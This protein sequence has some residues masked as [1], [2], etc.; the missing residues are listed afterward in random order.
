MEGA[1]QIR[2]A[3]ETAADLA[4]C[5]RVTRTAFG[6]DEEADLVQ[7]LLNDPSA[8]PVLSLLAFEDGQ[9][10]GHILFTAARLVESENGGGTDPSAALL[11]PL[12]VVPGAQGRGVG[13]RLI[14]AGLRILRD[15]GVD[16]VFVLGHPD[17]YP[18][19]GFHPAGA[20]GLDAPYSIPKEHADAWM[21]Q[22]LGPDVI[23]RVR[24]TVRCA[25]A[26]SKP[27]YWRE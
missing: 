22:A 12:S 20:H 19:H 7:A 3:A 2:E 15:R 10:V 9:A 11:A 25:N 4:E 5:L 23:G 13:G 8:A 27:E 18:R 14:E 26:I 16:L 1:I 21:V 17:Y 24:G 6:Q